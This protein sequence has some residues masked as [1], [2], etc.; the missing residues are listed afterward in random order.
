MTLLTAIASYVFAQ[1]SRGAIYQS[2]ESLLRS[3]A[4]AVGDVPVEEVTPAA[5]R[6]FWR[7]QG[8]LTR[9]HENKYSALKNFFQHLVARGHLGASPLTDPPP[10]VRRRFAP[11]IYSREEVQ[12][13]LDATGILQDRRH[14]LRPETFRAVLLLL[15]GTGLRCCEARRLRLCDA[16]LDD[17]LLRIWDTKFFQSRLVPF[18]TGLLTVLRTYRQARLDLPLPSGDRSALLASA[19]GTALSAEYLSRTFRR[20]R[21]QAGI[22]HPPPARWQPRLYD[23]RHT[24]ATHRLTSWYREGKDVQRLLPVL[25]T[26]LGHASIASTQAYLAMTPELLAEASRRFQRYAEPGP[27]G[28]LP[29]HPRP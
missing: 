27:E 8:P 7:G 22:R 23:M 10:R 21:S 28:A 3:F 14:P 26:Y 11:H 12:R 29:C 2:I 4:R 18:G 13:L 15:Y 25:A 9:S 24:F 17:R 20:I 5:V 19:R 6:M 1:R 16:D